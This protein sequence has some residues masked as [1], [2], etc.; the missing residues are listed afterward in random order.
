MQARQEAATR[1]LKILMAAALLLPLFLFVY[2]SW[3]VYA[4]INKAAD[5]RIDRSLEV[6]HEHALNIFH[7]VEFA[8]STLEDVVEGMPDEEIRK[9]EEKLHARLKK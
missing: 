7:S 3:R 9:N 6:L 2:S 1:V 4:D 8:I 5:E